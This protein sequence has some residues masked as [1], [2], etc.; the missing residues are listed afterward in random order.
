MNA[1]HLHLLVNHLPIIGAYL[2]LILLCSTML[3]RGDRG[4]FLATVIVLVIS[5]AG[6]LA[7]QFTGEPAEEVVEHLPDVPKTLIETHEEGALV[8]TILAGVT[9]LLALGL[10]FYALRREGLVPSPVMLVLFLATV[11]TCI[12]MTWVGSSGGKIR[13]SEIRGNDNKVTSIGFVS[14]I[15]GK[16]R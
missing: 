11:A 5:G 4:M 14:P 8:A 15:L 1:A 10:S 6:A 12:A 16:I 7:A 2:G 3:R 9:S 13:H